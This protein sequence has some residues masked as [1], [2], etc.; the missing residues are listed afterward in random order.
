MTEFFPNLRQLLHEQ[1]ERHRHKG[2]LEAAMA[3]CALVAAADGRVSLSERSQVDG[4][5]ESLED[6]KLFDPH[7]GVAVFN[8]YLEQ[9]QADP[10]TG[11]QQVL[12]AVGEQIR[13][14]PA[15]GPLLMRLC[16]AIS[17]ADGEPSPS[18][19][20]A[21]AGLCADLGLSLNGES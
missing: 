9:L 18:K 1:V 12:E 10:D 13:D 14:D 5:L 7:E 20:A 21:I 3:A 2:F 11:R 19:E 4:I 17:K 6:L 8:Q 16:Q 15:H